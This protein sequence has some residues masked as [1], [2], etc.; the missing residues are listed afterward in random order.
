M[1]WINRDRKE[2]ISESKKKMEWNNFKERVRFQKN[3]FPFVL[4]KLI[5]HYFS[6]VRREFRII[7]IFEK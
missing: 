2:K 7:D 3:L 6:Y 4:V 1:D 5:N